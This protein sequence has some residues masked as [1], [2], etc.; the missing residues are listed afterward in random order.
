M[1]WLLQSTTLYERGGIL[2]C[3]PACVLP[4]FI[5]F[6]NLSNPCVLP[7][8]TLS[9][10]RLSNSGLYSFSYSTFFVSMAVK[11]SFIPLPVPLDTPT[12]YHQSP[13]PSLY[14]MVHT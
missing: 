4:T 5:S 3:A 2:C 7:S 14:K 9:L 12:T 8:S 10:I 13:L 11:N 1:H 6:I